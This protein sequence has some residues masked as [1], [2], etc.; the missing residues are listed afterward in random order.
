MLFIAATQLNL[1][2]FQTPDQL[3][4]PGEVAHLDV[5]QLGDDLAGAGTAGE[6]DVDPQ[7]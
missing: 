7:R 5:L 2:R 3:F 1:T 6:V 4:A